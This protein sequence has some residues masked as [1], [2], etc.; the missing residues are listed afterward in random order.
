MSTVMIV[1]DEAPVRAL[2]TN[3]LRRAG[4]QVLDA[5]SAHTAMQMLTAQPCDVVICDVHMPGPNGLWLADR[6]RETSP[7][8]AI[9]LCTGDSCVPPVESLKRGIVGYLVKPFPLADLATFVNLGVS[10]AAQQRSRGD[11]T[12][13][14]ESR[15][16]GAPLTV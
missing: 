15:R 7:S 12:W 9:V 5:E 1:D 13:T 11:S 2:L 10:W 4:H 16:L 14:K 6:I 3:Y 8:T